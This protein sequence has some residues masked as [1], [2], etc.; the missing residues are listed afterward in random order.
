MDDVDVIASGIE[1]AIAQLV[2]AAATAAE[3]EVEA[4]SAARQ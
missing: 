1:T 4:E 3:Q 2:D